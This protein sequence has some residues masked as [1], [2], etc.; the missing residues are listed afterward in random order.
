MRVERGEAVAR[1]VGVE[2]N[3]KRGKN[4]VGMRVEG[5]KKFGWEIMGKGGKMA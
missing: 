5:V 1:E 4:G 2:N 3:G